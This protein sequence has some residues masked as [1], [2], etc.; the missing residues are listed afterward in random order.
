MTVENAAGC[1]FTA[2]LP[3]DRALP[4]AVCGRISVKVRPRRVRLGRTT[5]MRF[6]VT[7][8]AAGRRFALRGARIRIGGRTVRTDRLGRARVRY[9]PRGRPGR[10]RGCA[11]ASA[12]FARRGRPSACSA[13]ARR[14]A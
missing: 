11:W 2:A 10:R 7:R 12:A 9:R 5:R 4:P 3:F 6:R 1:S 8:V 14:S 13:A